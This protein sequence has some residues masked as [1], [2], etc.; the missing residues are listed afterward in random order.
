M[1][2]VFESLETQI[3]SQLQEVQKKLDGGIIDGFWSSEIPIYNPE[4]INTPTN[5]NFLQIFYRVAL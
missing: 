3:H 5:T 4:S 2:V 1:L